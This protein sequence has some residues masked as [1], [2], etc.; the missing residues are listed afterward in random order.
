MIK[1]YGMDTC[2]DFVEVQK[3]IKGNENFEFI[4]IGE[5]VMNLKEF[6]RLRDKDAVFDEAKAGGY[7]GIP[8]FVLESGRISLDPKDAGLK[9]FE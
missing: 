1:V 7:I 4:D 2:P 8:C 5:H 3:Q 6:L 9:N